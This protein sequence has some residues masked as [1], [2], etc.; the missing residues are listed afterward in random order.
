LEEVGIVAGH[1]IFIVS[2]KQ[3]KQFE[4]AKKNYSLKDN[5]M[6]NKQTEKMFGLSN[7][8]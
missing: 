8:F 5:K 7:R 2:V 6:T 3:M 4:H 1:T